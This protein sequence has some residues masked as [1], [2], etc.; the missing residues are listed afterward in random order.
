[1]KYSYCAVR[2]SYLNTTQVF[3][4]VAWEPLVVKS[5][6]IATEGG[7]LFHCIFCESKLQHHTSISVTIS[8]NQVSESSEMFQNFRARLKSVGQYYLQTYFFFCEC[9]KHMDLY[10]SFKYFKNMGANW[11]HST[12]ISIYLTKVPHKKKYFYQSFNSQQTTLTL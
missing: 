5:L 3:L 9:A 11:E 6:F 12:S 2:L 7:G 4:V 1:M 10:G 8:E